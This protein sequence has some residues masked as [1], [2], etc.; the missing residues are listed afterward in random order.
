MYSYK[1]KTMSSYRYDLDKSSKKFYCPRCN[2]KRFVRYIDTENNNN[3]LPE[4]YGNCDRLNNC[5]YSLNP[6]TDGYAKEVYKEEDKLYKPNFNKATHKA[7]QPAKS[8][9]SGSTKP[10][11]RKQYYFNSDIYSKSLNTDYFKDNSLFKCLINHFEPEKVKEVFQ[12]YKIGTIAKGY[13]KGCVLFPYIDID[14]NINAV[15]A[16]YYNDKCSR[17]YN[18]NF[19]HSILEKSYKDKA[20]EWLNNYL[21]NDSKVNTFFGTYLLNKFPEKDVIIVEG[22]KEALICSL[23]FPEYVCLGVYSLQT[24]TKDRAKALR[25][26]TVIAYPDLDIE[27]KAFYLWSDKAEEFKKGI[28]N[29]KINVINLFGILATEE[30]LKNGLDDIADLI[31]Y[32]YNYKTPE[33]TNLSTQAEKTKEAP[34]KAK[35]IAKITVSTSKPIERINTNQS[36]FNLMCSKNPNLLKL[37]DTFDLVSTKGIEFKEPIT[38]TKKDLNKIA[39]ESIGML[40]HDHKDNII[41][42][43][44]LFFEV[45][46]LQSEAYFIQMKK[47]NIIEKCRFKGNQ[48]YYNLSESTPF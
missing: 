12:L 3:Y 39:V 41:N 9:K 42:S 22:A 28:P 16:I 2:K 26:R 43:I 47:F 10:I 14:N 32:K 15:Q 25:G 40:N 18:P 11:I 36:L 19:L 7:K 33:N 20:P 21:K 35:T 37:V 23:F 29:L 45:D 30:D 6:Y 13:Y 1:L 48:F 31:L 5:G 8:P 4:K 44:G 38:A 34:T 24:F 27:N 46:K 17:K